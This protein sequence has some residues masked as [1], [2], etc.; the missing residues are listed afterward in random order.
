MFGSGSDMEKPIHETLAPLLNAALWRKPIKE[1]VQKLVAKHK[2]PA[3]VPNMT[4]PRLNQELFEVMNKEGKFQDIALQRYVGLV[5]KALIPLSGIISDMGSKTTKA[6]EHYLPQLNDTLQLLTASVNYM[7]HARTDGIRASI[8]HLP[9]NKICNWETKVGTDVVFPFDVVK[10]LEDLK[11]AKKLTS[12][13]TPTKRYGQ[14][15]GRW[16]RS[17][18]GLSRPYYPYTRQ[19]SRQG[20]ST[21]K[22]SFLGK[23]PQYPQ[24][25]R[26]LEHK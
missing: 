18:F 20:S 23:G 12:T 25:R 16:P 9:M 21:R 13:L 1:Q 11:K 2:I 22:R 8:R 14:G 5:T 24:S 17:R 7:N 10:K 6:V 3:N 19:P 26:I 15:V 4:T